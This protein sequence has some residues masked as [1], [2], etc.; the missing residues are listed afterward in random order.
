MSPFSIKSFFDINVK[1]AFGAQ[2]EE[3]DLRE[4]ERERGRVTLP[5]QKCDSCTVH[6]FFSSFLAG[7]RYGGDASTLLFTLKQ[8]M[9]RHT[10]NQVLS[11]EQV[12]QLPPKTEEDLAGTRA[13]PMNTPKSPHWIID[14]NH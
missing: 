10:K 14:P 1:Q 13:S 5:Q 2:G 7:G 11:G 3:K 6:T 4:R 8:C 12:L 9:V